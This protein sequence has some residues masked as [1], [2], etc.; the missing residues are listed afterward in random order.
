MRRITDYPVKEIILADLLK[1]CGG[2]R[3]HYIIFETDSEEILFD[4][5]AEQ[6]VWS[7]GEFAHPLCDRVIRHIEILNDGTIEVCLK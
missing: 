6:L 3:D 4:G 7:S 5:M 2:D 1:I